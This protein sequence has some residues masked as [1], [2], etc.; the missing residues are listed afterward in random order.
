MSFILMPPP[1][2]T[3]HVHR[4]TDEKTFAFKTLL[5]Q[6]GYP[7]MRAIQVRLRDGLLILRGNVSSYHMKQVAQEAIRPLAFGLR[8]KNEIHVH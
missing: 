2:A 4:V 1:V 5:R 6:S 7:E 8:I 3:P